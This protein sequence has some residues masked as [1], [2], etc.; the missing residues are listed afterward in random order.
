MTYPAIIPEIQRRIALECDRVATPHHDTIEFI[1]ESTV[2]FDAVIN[3]TGI[4]DAIARA[5]MLGFTKYV[6]RD[7]QANDHYLTTKDFWIARR[8]QSSGRSRWGAR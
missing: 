6:F 3:G 1:F 5:Y 8:P 7:L 4:R 2:K